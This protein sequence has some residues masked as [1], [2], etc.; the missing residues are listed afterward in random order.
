MITI[1]STASGEINV[2]LTVKRVVPFSADIYLLASSARLD[3]AEDIKALF[4]S[5]LASP[6][7]IDPYGETMLRVSHKLPLQD[8]QLKSKASQEA[9]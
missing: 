4:R 7:D 2:S 5:G 1:M 9:S 3:A 6:K 8:D